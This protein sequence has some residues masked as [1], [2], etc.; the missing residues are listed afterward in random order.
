MSASEV[1]KSGAP[2]QGHFLANGV[3]IHYLSQG[4]G[5]LVICTHGF[6]DNARTFRPMLADL[7]AAGFTA[8]AP[9]LRGYAPSRAAPPDEYLTGDMARDIVAVID[10]FGFDQAMLVGHDW[11]A[12]ASIAAAILF[13]E[14]IDRIVTLGWGRPTTAQ[15]LNHDYLKGIWHTFFFQSPQAEE[16]LTQNDCAFLDAWWRDASKG[17]DVPASTIESVKETFRV[18]GVIAAALAQ[19]RCRSQPVID[20]VRRAE[21]QRISTGPVAVPAFLMHGTQDREGRLE[22]FCGEGVSSYFSSFLSRTVV[23]GTGH[24]LHHERP[25]EVNRAIVDFLV[26]RIMR[27][28]TRNHG[29]AQANPI[30]RI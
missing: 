2:S 7:A 23:E 8:V 4:T 12:Q 17:W 25:V 29:I 24:F 19:Y 15:S 28:D 22:A 11:G 10:K 16:A 26:S 30:A 27:P 6:P 20:P 1:A 3:E 13:P 5:P 21:Q 14:R 18:P 9:Y